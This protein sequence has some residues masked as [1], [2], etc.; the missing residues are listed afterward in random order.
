M[1]KNGSTRYALL[2]E[3][4]GKL[5]ESSAHASACRQSSE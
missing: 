4:L 3:V 1:E 5:T 2:Y